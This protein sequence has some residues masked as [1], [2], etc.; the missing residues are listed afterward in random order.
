MKKDYFEK[1]FEPYD[2]QQFA[3]WLWQGLYSFYNKPRSDRGATFNNAGSI[4]LEHESVCEGIA[5]IYE[6][7][8]PANGQL[9]FR[10]AIGDVIREKSNNYS[11]YVQA[12]Q[13]LIYLIIRIEANESLSSL[14]PTVGSGVFGRQHPKV[15]Y[16]TISALASLSPSEYAY[17]TASDLID[18]ANFDDGYLFEATKILVECKPND[19]AK[20]VLRFEPRL[21][22]LFA[23]TNRIGG[24]EYKVFCEAAEN[25]AEFFLNKGTI[26]WLSELFQ[27]AIHSPDQKWLFEVL[28][29]NNNVPIF[30]N[31]DRESNF[32]IT[33]R[34]KKVMVQVSRKDYHTRTMLLNRK[35]RKE[36]YSWISDERDIVNQTPLSTRR[37]D[38]NGEIP[39][40]GEKILTKI[41]SL[42]K[43]DYMDCPC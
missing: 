14:L 10:Q 18:S 24:N 12:F 38:S 27:E 8:V 22:Q 36:A 15:L 41:A 3:D 13:D 35:S 5:Y 29:S 7:L 11:D 25:W 42:L 39:K 34:E 19:A 17:E 43:P 2:R 4:I 6:K 23:I 9:A 28:F 20:I 32:W 40:I 33:Y 21:T 1:L 31:W 30:L 26:T 16:E 37:I